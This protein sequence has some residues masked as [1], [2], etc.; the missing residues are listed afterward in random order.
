MKYVKP[1]VVLFLIA[2][3]ASGAL[4]YTY[5]FTNPIILKIKAKEQK[6]AMQRI[7]KDADNFKEKEQDG[8][9]YFSAFKDGKE[10]GRIFRE[11]QKGYS[12]DPI[13]L[14]VGVSSGKVKAV[15]VVEQTETPGL[16]DNVKQEWFRGQFEEKS[17]DDQ[18]TVKKDIDAITGATISSRAVANGVKSALEKNDKLRIE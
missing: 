14:L 9:I 10:I 15:E 13:I 1:V 8:V 3:V 12:A 18:L 17:L 7:F 2:V 4:A 5:G 11:S 16:G 6:E